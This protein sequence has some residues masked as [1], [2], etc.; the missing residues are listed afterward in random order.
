[1]KY[2]L[3]NSNSMERR[4]KEEKY[5]VSMKRNGNVHT[6]ELYNLHLAKKRNLLLWSLFRT[7]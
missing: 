1:M 6:A 3:E 5:R 7:I 2:P 4:V